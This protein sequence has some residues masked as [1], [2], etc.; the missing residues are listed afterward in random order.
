MSVYVCRRCNYEQSEQWEGTCPRCGGFYRAKKVGVDS[1]EQKGRSTFAAADEV[2]KTYIPT[3]VE[4]FDR[5]IGGGLVAGSPILFGGFRGV[6]KTT[7]LC[8]IVDGI[9][10]TKG[11]ALY[12][13]SEESVDG[14][15]SIAHRLGLRTND[16]SVLGNQHTVERVI[17]HADKMR[18][19]PFVVVYDSLQK[20]VSDTSSA[21][22]GSPAQDSAV[23]AAVLAYCR[24]TKTC[25]IIVN[26][27]AKSGE[28]KGDTDAAHAVDTVLIFAFPKD[29]DEDAPDEKDIRVLLCD[30]KN[31]NGPEN[32]KSYWRMN[33]VGVLEEVQGRSLL[34]ETP[35]RGKYSRRS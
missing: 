28:M 22:A 30:G 27:M 11:R 12:A 25:A 9:A 24:R 16:V 21:A 34:D 15:L 20:Y 35:R 32:I 14:V 5:V 4:G 17:E 1:D 2:K 33:S 3:G 6:G 10:K 29:G 13:S 7:L 19:R 23:A 8:C 18:P 31:R 26:Q